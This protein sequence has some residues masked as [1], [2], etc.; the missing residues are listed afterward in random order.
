[1]AP[2][3]SMTTPLVALA[4][5]ALLAA[6]GDALGGDAPLR[7]VDPQLAA[8][9]TP[10]EDG[11]FTCL[12]MSRT[13]PISRVNDDF[14]DCV[15]DGS[16][17]PGACRHLFLPPLEALGVALFLRV[18]WVLWRVCSYALSS[19]CVVPDRG[20][21]R[22]ARTHAPRA[23]TSACYHGRFYCANRGH[24]PVR[25]A[26]AFVDDGVCGAWHAPCSCLCDPQPQCKR[27]R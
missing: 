7:G 25:L 6:G 22:H 24:H 27:H 20:G 13:I 11:T 4:L 10:A 19:S 8:A 15:A 3:R 9:Y 17:E 5:L 12:D 21:G 18:L 2:R 23:G 16:D 14:C 1:M 26:S